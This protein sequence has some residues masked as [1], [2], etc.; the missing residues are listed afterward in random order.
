MFV[1]HVQASIRGRSAL[2]IM[3]E[4]AQWAHRSF[5]RG[6]IA[7]RRHGY[8]QTRRV[9][10]PRMTA[11]SR[12]LEP[13]RLHA[14]GPACVCAARLRGTQQV[15]CQPFVRS[16]DGREEAG[17]DLEWLRPRRKSR[18]A[19]RQHRCHDR[20][21]SPAAAHHDLEPLAR[22]ELP[23]LPVPVKHAARCCAA[24]A[25]AGCGDG[26]GARELHTHLARSRRRGVGRCGCGG[27]FARRPQR[28]GDASASLSAH[29]Q[30]RPCS[31]CRG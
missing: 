23:E 8:T 10:I 19:A 24:A 16:P 29:R 31:A 13:A 11:P 26:W 5:R 18:G 6:L 15:S 3:R 9:R 22:H 12:W 14:P 7:V 30:C 1:W 25:A 28:V 2:E 4:R 20:P 21:G 27:G 17:G